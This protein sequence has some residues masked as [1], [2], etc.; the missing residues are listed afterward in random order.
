VPVLGDLV[1]LV[2]PAAEATKW[3]AIQREVWT[4]T[5]FFTDAATPA[6]AVLRDNEFFPDRQKPVVVSITAALAFPAGGLRAGDCAWIGLDLNDRF[7]AARARIRERLAATDT[8]FDSGVDY[9]W[10]THDLFPTFKFDFRPAAAYLDRLA[11]HFEGRQPAGQDCQKPRAPGLLV[12]LETLP[13]RAMAV[14]L[15]TFPFQVTAAEETHTIGNLD[16]PRPAAGV[17]ADALPSAAPFGTTH[18]LQG[19]HASGIEPHHPYATLADAPIDCPLSNRWLSRARAA[20]KPQYGLF[21]DSDI[22]AAE[23]PGAVGQGPPSAQFLHGLKLTGLAP[24]TRANDPFW[25]V[26]AFDNALSRHDGYR[27]S[28]FICA[29]A[30]LVLDDTTGADA[31][32]SGRMD[33]PDRPMVNPTP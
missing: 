7:R 17:L 20:Q 19:H 14:V 3:T 9:D 4:R 8:M 32:M 18:E 2:N 10:A 27:L 33:D 22:L 16:P 12:A 13:L 26:R 30:Q 5:A 23:E 29:V 28:S 11:A 1:V 15:G 6:E 21:W 24:I 25:N 31:P